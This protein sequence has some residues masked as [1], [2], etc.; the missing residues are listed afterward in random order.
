MITAYFKNVKDGRL[1]RLPYFG[2]HWLLVFVGVAV[3]IGLG[4]ATGGFEAAMAAGG[5][6]MDEEAMT[7]AYAEAVGTGGLLTV[8]VAMIVLGFAGLN[9]GAKR[10]R[11][12][13]L[14]GW[15]AMFA[16]VIASGLV[17]RFASDGF[18]GIYGVAVSLFMWLT[19]SNT[20][21]QRGRD[22]ID[23]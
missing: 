22:V 9:I 3:I 20:F 13:G 15:I 12:M 11:D 21:G 16:L 23:A 7:E 17:D 8:I 18:A 2:Y 4:M 19:P 1:T 5:E 14:P 10:L 6:A